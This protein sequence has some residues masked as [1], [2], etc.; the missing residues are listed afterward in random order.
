MF[1]CGW[2]VADNTPL[3]L[4]G[5]FAVSS[6]SGEINPEIPVL[7]DLTTALLV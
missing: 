3:V 4:Y 1:F 6:P 5:S 2:T 7:A